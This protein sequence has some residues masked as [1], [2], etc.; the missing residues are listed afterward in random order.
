MAG[1]R[2]V[3]VLW[4]TTEKAVA[5]RGPLVSVKSVMTTQRSLKRTF[6]ETIVLA[7][8]GYLV[9]MPGAARREACRPGRCHMVMAM[10]EVLGYELSTGTMTGVPV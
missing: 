8:S 9:D 10:V 5:V 6:M 4:E 2:R 1:R 7:F 3:I